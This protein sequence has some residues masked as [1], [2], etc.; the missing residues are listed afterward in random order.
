MTD[1]QEQAARAAR[2]F[3]LS[4]ATGVNSIDDAAKFGFEAGYLAGFEAAKAEASKHGDEVADIV[5]AFL[6]MHG[7]DGLWHPDAECACEVDD[8]C[9]CDQM[10]D[11][12]AAG[13]KFGCDCGDHDFHIGSAAVRDHYLAEHAEDKNGGSHD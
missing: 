6:E 13:Y 12:C 8:L 11:R 5:C 3:D 2:K 4:V 7:Y 1:I 9:P 10:S